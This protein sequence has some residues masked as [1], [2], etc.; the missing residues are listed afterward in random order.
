MRR[1]SLELEFVGASGDDAPGDSSLAGDGGE[2]M[3][4]RYVVVRDMCMKWPE[5]KVD[6]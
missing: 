4:Q 5:R 1:K 6:H 3:A 2:G